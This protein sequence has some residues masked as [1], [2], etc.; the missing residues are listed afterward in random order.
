MG[1]GVHGPFGISRAPCREIARRCSSGS[2]IAR[3]IF[4]SRRRL[5]GFSTRLASTTGTSRFQ[6]LRGMPCILG[7]GREGSTL[8]PQVIDEWLA[9]RA[10]CRHR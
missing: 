10:R 2:R 4:I 8:P 7:P 5:I 9:E 6:T 3:T 1:F